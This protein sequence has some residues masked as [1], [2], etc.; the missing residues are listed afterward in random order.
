VLYA[1]EVLHIG[2]LGYALLLAMLAVGAVLGSVV[3]SRLVRRLG[4]TAVIWLAVGLMTLAM[5]TPG[6]VSSVAPVVV[7]LLAGGASSMLW[8]VVTISLRQTAVPERLL[9]RV[10]SAYR[11]IGMGSMPV[12]AA[13]GGIV[14][15]RFGLHAPW[16]VAGGVL[17]VA[18]VACAPFVRPSE[19]EEARAVDGPGRHRSP[20]STA[21]R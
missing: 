11:V 15:H 12:G 1:L 14:A 17:V 4:A 16:L 21:A 9:G 18:I 7:A 13:I 20:D 2:N 10:T 5:L 3:A 19:V 6:L 8:N